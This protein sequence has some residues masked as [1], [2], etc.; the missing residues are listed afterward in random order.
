M[1]MP[2]CTSKLTR[3]VCAHVDV[4]DGVGVLEAKLLVQCVARPGLTAS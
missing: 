3:D 4:A 2:L 1:P